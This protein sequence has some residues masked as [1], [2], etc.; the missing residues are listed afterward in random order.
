MNENDYFT[1]RNYESNNRFNLDNFNNDDFNPRNYTQNYFHNNNQNDINE[2][3]NHL[4][5]PN[6]N[7]NKK[8]FF[9]VNSNANQ[10]NNDIVLFKKRINNLQDKLGK[11][12]KF[13]SEINKAISYKFDNKNNNN[14]DIFNESLNK[15]QNYYE[16][17][18]NNYLNE[19][20]KNLKINKS[21]DE[22]KI[23][24]N[25]YDF[26]FDPGNEENYEEDGDNLDN[27]FEEQEDEL[28]DNNNIN[29]NMNNQNKNLDL[30]DNEQ[31]RDNSFIGFYDNV[32]ASK[33][34]ELLNEE[35][36]NNMENDVPENISINLYN[37]NI[38]NNINKKYD[39]KNM[40]LYEQNYQFNIPKVTKNNI[41]DDEDKNKNKNNIQIVSNGLSILTNENKKKLDKENNLNDIK[42]KNL[43][44]NEIN[45][46]IQNQNKENIENNKKLINLEEKRKKELQ[47]YD[48]IIAKAKELN[49]QFNLEQQGHELKEELSNNDKEN[50]INKK[51]Q[52]PELKNKE[53]EKENIQ[54]NSDKNNIIKLDKKDNNEDI[55]V[56]KIIKKDKNVSFIE[57]KIYIKYEQED[58]IL[59]TNVFNNKEK[60]NF[61]THDLKKYIHRLKKKEYLEPSII[62]CPN[63][64][65]N[66]INNDIINLMKKEKI[67]PNQ[68]PKINNRL[69]KS[70]KNPTKMKIQINKN[71]ELKNVKKIDKNGTKSNNKNN[72]IK[73]I[74]NTKNNKNEKNIKNITQDNLKKEKIMKKN[75]TDKLLKP[76]KDEKNENKKKEIK[77]LDILNDPIFKEGQRA[78]NNLKKF[79]EENNLDEENN[80]E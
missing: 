48:I 50:L 78:I 14:N 54:S 13:S 1:D 44:K 17:Y 75:K 72:N 24:F 2:E 46:I 12:N 55:K 35:M 51:D 5:Y 36:N 70:V 49:N 18:N 65:Y 3:I 69:N 80:E 9:K 79:F 59:K 66:K 20:N 16:N 68:N 33:N 23:N 21:Y 30:K 27:N 38:I 8:N 34:F 25:N 47:N 61:V 63:I 15:T 77:N 32:F 62:N 45:N 11:L 6:N 39:Y 28:L 4:Y 29:N 7:L 57:D 19:N 40:Q 53:K 56:R 60:I 74:K 37:D 71:D 41:L 76:K 43:L 10:H 22:F 64:N 31:F 58:Y 67:V 42:D 73:I 26:M 52:N